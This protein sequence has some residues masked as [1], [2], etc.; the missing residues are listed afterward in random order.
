[1]EG[2]MIAKALILPGIAAMSFL[3]T[4]AAEPV[5]LHSEPIR[6]T[7]IDADFKVNAD[8]NVAAVEF[9]VDH[10]GVRDDINLHPTKLTKAVRDLVY[11]PDAQEVRY[12]DVVCAKLHKSSFLNFRRHSVRE[13]GACRFVK[14]ESKQWVDNGFDN[15]HY[16]TVTDVYLHVPTS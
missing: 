6:A 10:D 4:A 15:P 3:T 11:V 2:F 1:M 13:T 12:K 8:R 7:R 9:V 16:Q 5:L 14:K